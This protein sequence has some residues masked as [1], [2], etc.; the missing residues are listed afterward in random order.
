MTVRLLSVAASSTG[1][2]GSSTCQAY[3]TMQQVVRLSIFE[4]KEAENKEA[5]PLRTVYA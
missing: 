3:I 2:A 4:N 1:Y 5:V